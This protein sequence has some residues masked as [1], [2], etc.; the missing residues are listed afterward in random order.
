MIKEHITMYFQEMKSIFDKHDFHHSPNR[1]WN[2]DETG[3]T[4][5]HKPPKVIAS[6]APKRCTGR[7]VSPGKQ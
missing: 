4:M 6:K 7:Q 2:M 3:I 5:C 1:I